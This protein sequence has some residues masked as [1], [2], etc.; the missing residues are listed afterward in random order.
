MIR[1]LYNWAYK[2][3]TQYI[4]VRLTCY[5]LF[6]L[7]PL[8]IVSLFS[9]VKS[10]QI[11]K[12]QAVERTQGAMRSALEY[13]DITLK[14]I[15]HIS[16]I[17]ATDINI[18]KLMEQTTANLGREE[19]YNFAQVL[20]DISSIRVVNQ[21][22]SSIA[23][24]H[25][26]SEMV[27]MTNFG[28]KRISGILQQAWVAKTLEANGASIL[29][30]PDEDEAGVFNKNSVS[31]IR[32]INPYNT[33][34]T[35]SLLIMNIEKQSLF[36]LTAAL[37][38]SENAHIYLYTSDD[39]LV[40][41]TDHNRP[42]ELNS[43]MFTV[44][45][46]SNYSNWKLVMAQ[47]EQELYEQTKQINMY[48]YGII[49]IS[50]ILALWIS[51]VVYTGIY[52]PLER[53]S[54]GMKQLRIGNLNIQLPNRRQDELGYLTHSF[55]QMVS[56]QKHLIQDYY[57]QQLRLSKTELQFLQSQINPHFLYNTLDSIYWTAKNYDAD[58]ISEM[59]LNLSKFFRLSLNKG[60]EVL[61]LK[62]SIEH[63]HYYIRVQQLR[64]NNQFEV[65]YQIEEDTESIP[66]L[67]LLLQPLVENAILH[68]L[69]KQ[70]SG[71]KLKII[72][73]IEGSNLLLQVW[74][75]GISMKP[76]RLAY[77]QKQLELAVI[78]RESNG[79]LFGMKNLVA[80]IGLYYG[81][82]AKFFIESD[83]NEGTCATIKLPLERCTTG[84]ELV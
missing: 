24:L 32:T 38:P 11:L 23:I 36:N 79:E 43:D 82:E 12:E 61:L 66:I 60:R 55:N 49:G 64:F 26:P 15:D 20:Q 65:E 18:I 4:Q 30:F 56:D 51:W 8:V 25:A 16:T 17:I 27:L 22:I 19:I 41:S 1:R 9:N 84:G 48:T 5:F 72:S 21:N 28:G 47:P 67:K 46:R 71:G 52:T 14:N 37:R 57:E 81:K 2:R 29:H 3:F 40:A 73:R 74:N 44:E 53:L 59:V 42:L 7:I 83:P 75:N 63:L 33:Q 39:Q 54:Y 10:Q 58:E 62:E 69:E 78:D 68:G 76:E 6:I 34:R 80:R 45:I 13:I 77:V 70:M 50:I 35:S 31:F